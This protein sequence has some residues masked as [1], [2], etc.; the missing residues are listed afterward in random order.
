MQA[1]ERIVVALDVPSLDEA[2]RLVEALAPHVGYFKVGLELITAVGG[3]AAVAAVRE[4]GGRVMY[5]AKFHDIPATM[6]GAARSVSSLGVDLFTV[7]SSAGEDGLKSVVG[8]V[9][10]ERVVGVTVLTSMTDALCCRIYGV[11]PDTAVVSFA[12]GLVY[13]GVDWIVCSP[14]ELASLA[15]AKLPLKPITPGVRP[16]WADSN[17]QKRVMTPAEA[18]VAGA[19]LLVIGR[20][21]LKP[22]TSVGTPVEAAKRI[23]DEIAGALQ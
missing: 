12:Y 18:T 14:Q 23:A 5:D 22:P 19:R 13:A 2:K 6:A 3:P 10:G 1:H 8:A 17:D 20:P 7:H 9:G 4:V 16:L 21:I 15:A 11:K